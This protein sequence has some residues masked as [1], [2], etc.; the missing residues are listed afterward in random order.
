VNWVTKS[1]RRISRKR[2]LERWETKIENC[3]INLK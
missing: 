1:I 3:E 2:V